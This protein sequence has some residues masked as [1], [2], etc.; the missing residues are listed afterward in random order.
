MS[1]S[2]SS[3]EKSI[4]PGPVCAL[5]VP[6]DRPDRFA[7]AAKSGADMMIIDLED[8]V[9]PVAKAIARTNVMEYLRQANAAIP[10]AVRINASSSQYFSAD[11][12]LLGQLAVAGLLPIEVRVPKVEGARDLSDVVMVAGSRVAALVE[13]AAGLLAAAQIAATAGVISIGLGESD[14]RSELML[15][16][17]SGFAYPRSVIVVAA[18]AAGL[19]SPAM[20]A[21]ADLPDLVGLAASCAMGRALG[22][23]GRSAVHPSQIPVIREAFRPTAA[24]V[25]AAEGSLERLDSALTAAQGVIRT[26]SGAMAD[27][28]MRHHAETLLR[29][30]A[31]FGPESDGR[32]GEVP[33]G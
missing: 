8:S 22:C 3:P 25:T 15:E 13:S 20:A 33:R 30:S 28:A 18:A 9:A 21:F 2:A 27:E 5:Y 1:V 24:A 16:G 14:L 19:R 29:R 11:V 17:E 31:Q 32:S 23:Y 10:V 26:S 4:Y 6:G 7:K 12:L